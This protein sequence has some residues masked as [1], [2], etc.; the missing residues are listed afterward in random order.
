MPDDPNHSPALA[1][2]RV[3]SRDP[4]HA[5]WNRLDVVTIEMAIRGAPARFTREVV[6]HGNGAAVLVF[7]AA[8][9]TALLVRQLRAGRLVAEGD[10]GLL[11]VPAGL[12]DGSEDPAVTAR[13]EVSE[14][15]GVG[16][17]DL[18]FV[19]AAYPSAS[20]LTER[21]WLYLG[22]IDP[23]HPRAPAA[24]LPTSTRKSRSSTCRS[25]TLPPMPMPA[26]LPT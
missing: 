13:R 15:T 22:E 26:A 14:E 4:R 19:A 24:A 1:A 11:E 12:V 5:G 17:R 8:Q 6:D 9:K 21:I 3:L 16:L 23:A 2:A 10:G 18:V 20:S 7:D 25:S